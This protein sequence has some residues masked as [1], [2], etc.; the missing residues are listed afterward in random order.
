MK[1]SFCTI[2]DAF[3]NEDIKFRFNTLKQPIFNFYSTSCY[4]IPLKNLGPSKEIVDK[5]FGGKSNG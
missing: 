3:M 2:N 4:G 5:Y 1:L